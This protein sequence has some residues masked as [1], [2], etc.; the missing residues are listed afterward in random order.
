MTYDHATGRVRSGDVDLFYRRFGRSHRSPVLIS[1]GL[2]FFSYDWIDVAARL[3]SNREVVAM[4]MRGFGESSW[5]PAKDYK[6]ETLSRD[7]IYLL[8]ALDWPKAVL[9]GHSFGGRIALATAGWHPDRA[10]ALICVDFAPD[11]AP[12]GRR[13]V[14]ERIGRQPDLFA[15]VEEALRYHG[16]ENEP[17][18]SAVRTRYEAFLQKGDGGYALRR[19]IYFR[20]NFRRALETG[21]SAPV[22]AFL[23]P[24][25]A[26]V[27]VPTLV[28]RGTRSDM[29][30]PE[31]AEKVRAINERVRVVELES[32][33]DIAGEYP[34]GLVRAVHTFLDEA[35]V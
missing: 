23:W 28:I 35:G 17:A 10:A 14:A 26:D 4:D 22:P 5:S 2:S 33:H 24:M 29:L 9:M 34:M 21:Q 11:I 30:A 1:H 32:G 16:H 27:R 3:A 6:L 8:D 12:A 13:H 18:G 7:A 15:S 19:D 31:T 20:D 25:L